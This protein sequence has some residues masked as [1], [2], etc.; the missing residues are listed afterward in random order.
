MQPPVEERLAQFEPTSL[1]ADLSGVPGSER[2]VLGD[3]I[4]AARLMDEVFLRQVWTENPQMRAALADAPPPVREYFEVNFGPWDRLDDMHPFVDGA[5][6]HPPGAGYYPTDLTREELEGWIAEHPEQAEA[7]TSLYTVVRRGPEAGL[8]AEPY[9]VVYREWLEPA[10]ALL[11][12]AAAST[13]NASLRRYLELRA[14]AF[15]SDDYYESDLAWMDLD[16]PVEVTIGPYEVYEDSLFGYKAAFEAFVTVDLPQQSAELERFKAL[17]PTLERGLPIP[18][19]H[20]NLQ[21]GTESPM[22]VVDVVFV[23]GDSK[24]GVQTTA[25]NLPNDERVREEKGSKKVL[26]RNVMRAKYEKILVPIAQR[27]LS[28]EQAEQVS[29]EA[30]FAEVLHHELSHGLGPGKIRKDGRD[31]EVRLELRDLYSTL[32]EAKADVMGV[33]NILRLIDSGEIDNS[34]RATLEPTYVA[35]LFRSARF[36]LHEAHGRGVVSQ[37]NYLLEHGSLVVD[38]EGRFRVDSELFPAGI[39]AL[40]REMLMLQATGD[41]A[42]TAAFLDRYG[43]ATPALEGAIARLDDVPVDIRPEYPQAA[44]LAP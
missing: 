32:E 21:R 3:L 13:G 27:V 30:F 43:I 26:L 39:E 19:E 31:T 15:A 38:E 2:A 6:P 28:G 35:G 7:M 41:Y 17:L 5:P 1:D 29:F 14:D 11:R 25:F 24:A 9:S 20:K 37:F 36:G 40:L 22:R 33:Y 18:D 44:A 23:G 42:G 8:V 16:A 12:S 34:L 4:R 10:A